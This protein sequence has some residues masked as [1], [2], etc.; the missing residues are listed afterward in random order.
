MHLAP[1][2]E[3]SELALLGT[4]P[5]HAEVYELAKGALGAINRAKTQAG[6][7]VG[8]HV[9]AL[10]ITAPPRILDL[11]A[12]AEGDILAATRVLSLTQLSVPET[13]EFDLGTLVKAIDLAPVPEKA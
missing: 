6:G 5:E 13:P 12:K 8:R 2:P 7:T 9:S 11:F 10:T 1:W 3:S 4:S